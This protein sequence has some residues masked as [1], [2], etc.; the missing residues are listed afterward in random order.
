MPDFITDKL[1]TVDPRD[2]FY[3]TG[4]LAFFGLTFLPILKQSKFVSVPTIYVLLGALLALSPVALPFIDPRQGGLALTVVEH[5]SELIVIVSLAGAGLAV[6]R[7]MGLKSWSSC[8]R[9]LAIAMPL[10]IAAIV[11]LSMGMLGLPLATAM[12]LG[13]SLA[14]TDPVLARSV[15]VGAPGNEHDEHEVQVALTAEAG[16]NDGLAFP[17]VYFAIGLAGLSNLADGSLLVPFTDTGRLLEWFGYDLLYRVGIGVVV[18]LTVGYALSTIVYSDVGDATTEENNSGLT[19][20]SAT[21]LSYGITELFSGYGFLAVFVAARAA[22]H[23]AR[24]HHKEGYE[25]QPHHFADQMEGLLMA[26]LL[27]WFGALL[28]NGTI[29]EASSAEWAF[30]ALL[31]FG[32]RPVAG[33]LALL[34]RPCTWLERGAIAFFGIRGMGSVFYLAYGQNHAEFAAMD[35]AWRVAALTI[36]ISVVVHGATAPAAVGLARKERGMDPA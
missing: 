26:L 13:A 8:W 31:V 36:L 4:G 34:G 15:Q 19:L 28:V 30:A 3:T 16:L 25:E 1:L 24:V 5:A 21:F 7:R 10:T 35:T 6:D 22:R 17:F 9:L 12:L 18:G 29:T 27:L 11:F 2:V 23:Y 20:M 33:L 14:P 32:V